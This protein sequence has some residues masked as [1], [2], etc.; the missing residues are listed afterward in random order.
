MKKTLLS[1]AMLLIGMGAMAQNQVANKKNILSAEELMAKTEAVDIVIQNI[2]TSNR[3]YFCGNKN[4]QTYETNSE[5]WFVW[6]PS[7]DT[8]TF[9]LKKKSP[10]DGQGEGYLQTGA[11][12]SNIAIGAKETAQKFTAEYKFPTDAPEASADSEK[13]VRFV[14][15]GGADWIN[16]Q[17]TNGTSKYNTGQGAWTMHNV[18]AIEMVEAVSFTY[19]YT[20]G[21]KTVGSESFTLAPGVDYPAASNLPVGIAATLPEG[22]V[23]AADAGTT[24]DVPCTLSNCPVEFAADAES[25]TKWYYLGL[26]STAQNT[27]YIQYLVDEEFIDWSDNAFGADEIDSHLWGFVG[28][29]FEVKVVSKA[30]NAGVKS[31]GTN[32]ATVD[33]DATA[34]YM[35]YGKGAGAGM[36]CLQHSN[37]NYLNGQNNGN[38]G[39][40]GKV[41]HWSDNDAGSVFI[42]VE[43]VET[44]VDFTIDY[45]TLFLGYQAYIPESVKAYVVSSTTTDK[46]MMTE[47]EGIIPANTGVVLKATTGAEC[48]LANA[49]GTAAAVEVNLLNGT[50]E[51]VKVEGPAY[52]LASVEGRVAFYMAE[53][54][55][56]NKFQNN[57]NKAYLPVASEA[58]C[59]SFDFG[60]ET[61][62]D[63]LNGENGNEKTV[64]YDLSGRRVQKAQKGVFVVNGKVVIK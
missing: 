43:Y 13:L 20:Y 26:H 2:S 18:Y 14:R 7:G 40:V 21:G 30:A 36:F 57:A 15:E 41:W 24:I 9:Y 59:L 28:N 22:K 31:N 37:G 3:W 16:C 10:V 47:I 4:V 62:I 53:L 23:K 27:K 25:I 11:S 34:F 32:A 52:V 5:A 64:I 54:D 35:A 55:G 51:T 42:P 8:K 58:R 60:T 44:E 17:A 33:A 49:I 29:P 1:F 46:A 61:A 63:E 56:E 12:G 39:N 48:K 38:T 6:E 50:T 19:N 45:A